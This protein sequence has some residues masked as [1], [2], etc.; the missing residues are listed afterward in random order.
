MRA[1]VYVC[2]ESFLDNRA[3]RPDAKLTDMSGLNSPAT[4]AI[5]DELKGVAPGPSRN[6]Y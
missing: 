2:G 4:T 3:Y 6:L 1:F 5:S